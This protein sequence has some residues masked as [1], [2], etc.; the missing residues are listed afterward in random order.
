MAFKNG[1]IVLTLIHHSD[2]GTQHASKEFQELL[3]TNNILCSISRKGNCWGNAVAESFLHTLNVEL[4]H[5]K[6]HGTRQKAKTTFF[7]YIEIIYNRQ[8]PH[9]YLSYLSPIDFEIKNVD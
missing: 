5:G 2:R 6:V 1:C 4:I 7:D 3:K 8:R 9:S